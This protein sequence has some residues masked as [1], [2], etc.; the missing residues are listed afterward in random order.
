M[1]QKTYNLKSDEKATQVMIGTADMLIWGD[2]VT[3]EHVRIFAFLTTLAED[4]VVVHDAKVLFLAPAQQV[5]P[6]DR[7][8]VYVKLEEI[9]MFYSMSEAV[10]L[11]EE[12]E[13]RRY[14]PM[15]FIVGPFQ[16]EGDML[17]SPIASLQNVLLVSK[18]DYLPLYNAKVRHVS[19]PWLGTFSSSMVQVQRARL[20]VAQP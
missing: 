19:K 18:D 16:I 15:E 4:F 17:K 11:P 9:L 14:E 10:P 20:T 8:L 5:A 1:G 2:L 3:K 13:V 7:A 6:V 12:S